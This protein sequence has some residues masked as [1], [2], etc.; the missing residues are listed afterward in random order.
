MLRKIF[1]LALLALTLHAMLASRYLH[2]LGV[3][4][5]AVLIK[6]QLRGFAFVI[7]HHVP[8]KFL[9]PQFLHEPFRLPCSRKSATSALAVFLNL[10]TRTLL[11]SAPGMHSRTDRSAAISV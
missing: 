9:P 5:Y 11:F 6:A 4:H 2:T 1:A 3:L 7:R 8:Q 10:G